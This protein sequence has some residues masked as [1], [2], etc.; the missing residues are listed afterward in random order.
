MFCVC[1]ESLLS[2]PSRLSSGVVFVSA[3]RQKNLLFIAAQIFVCADKAKSLIICLEFS[4]LQN[5]RET[6]CM[7]QTQK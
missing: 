1:G 4:L 5:T 2:L 7:V 3:V 6:K